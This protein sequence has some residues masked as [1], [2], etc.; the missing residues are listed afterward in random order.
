MKDLYTRMGNCILTEM[1][2][3]DRSLRKLP[4]VPE[5]K[6]NNRRSNVRKSWLLSSALWNLKKSLKSEYEKRLNEREHDKL[7]E[8]EER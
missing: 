8:E 3:Y 5:T 4:P 1:R 2:S 6:E 7:V